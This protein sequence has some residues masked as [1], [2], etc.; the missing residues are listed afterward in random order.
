MGMPNAESL[1]LE[2]RILARLRQYPVET[3]AG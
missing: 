3:L 2:E 1:P